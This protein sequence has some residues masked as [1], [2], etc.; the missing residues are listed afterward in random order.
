M[1]DTA[2]PSGGD[3]RETGRSPPRI[4]NPP[5][6]PPTTY[7]KNDYFRDAE[8]ILLLQEV[9]IDEIGPYLSQLV[10]DVILGIARGA[11]A[12]LDSRTRGENRLKAE[13]RYQDDEQVFTEA[14]AR[15]FIDRFVQ[16]PA[17]NETSAVETAQERR[18]RRR[19]DHG[20]VEDAY[21]IS[22]RDTRSSPGQQPRYQPPRE[23]SVFPSVAPFGTPFGMNPYLASSPAMGFQQ[24]YQYA[25]PPTAQSQPQMM[26]PS[27]LTSR[28][29]SGRRLKAS[30][31]GKFDG[32]GPE[33]RKR[34]HAP[35]MAPSPKRTRVDNGGLIINGEL[36]YFR[37]GAKDFPHLLQ[38]EGQAYF[39]RTGYISTAFSMQMN[40]D[41]C[42]RYATGL[43]VQKDIDERKVNPGKYFVLKF[44]FS[45]INPHPDLTEA[46]EALIKML[47]SSIEWFYEEYTAYLGGKSEALSQDIDSKEPNI[48]L[49]KCVKSV[50]RAIKNDEQLAGIKGIYV[51][52]D[53]YDAFPNNYLE[54]PKTVG[55]PKIAWED[56]AVG[57]TFKSF[58]ATIKSLCADGI[59]QRIFITGISPLSL[60]V[61]GSGFNVARNTSFDKDL[62]GLC[63]LTYSDLEDALKGIYEDPEVYNG[64]L[65][66][67]TKFF[68]GYHFCNDET[69]ETVYNTE[70]CLAYL[71]RR[72]E[73]KTPETRDPENS[74]VSEQFLKRFAAST[75]VIRDFEKAL[76]CDGKGNFMPVEYDRFRPEFTLRDL[77]EDEDYSSWRSLTIYFGGLTFHPEKPT[78]HLKIPNRVAADRIALAVLRKYG[79]CNSLSEALR[80]PVD[81]GELEQTLGCYREL[82]MQRDVTTQDLTQTHE[83]AHRDSFY[84]SLLQ[85]HFLAPRAEFKVIKPNK[86]NGRIDLILQIPGQLI[87]TEWKFYR[88]NFLNIQDGDTY[89]HLAKADILR[90]YNLS[91]ILQLR[92]ATWDSHHEGTI[93]SWVIGNEARQLRDYI[94][95]TEIQQ[96]VEKDSLKLQAHFVIVV[97][98]R[99]ILLWDMDKEGNLAAEPRLVQVPSRSKQ[100]G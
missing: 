64:F 84:F 13:Q 39:D 41:G 75:P 5:S 14:G 74:E 33:T 32:A 49:K 36:K 9:P 93:R 86:T 52:V 89:A 92:F 58:W 12:A 99:H 44:D 30:E 85:N 19:F 34:K 68:H 51:L 46:N 23:W 61:L 57:R 35:E 4:P 45:K 81:Y 62:A 100:T 95:S 67:M 91:K 72:I 82:M 87:V 17:L 96:K 29:T 90:D 56:T 31:M 8:F 98:S 73:R 94:K 7:S 79:L 88:I 59:I 60:S 3:S 15:A 16:G 20:P 76:E 97:G 47:N 2:G 37:S 26:Q 78:T 18:R 69:V 53:E 11:V 6:S 48:S 40:I 43:D 83:A 24:P 21:A 65:S 42:T 25:P 66:E 22:H 28:S 77:N 71:Q 50:R 63:G 80:Y 10:T 38:R 54:P 55:R 70:T 27:N 1:D